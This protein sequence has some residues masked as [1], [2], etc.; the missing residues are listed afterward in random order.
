MEIMMLQ[1]DFPTTSVK[2]L[3][4]R[5]G[6]TERAIN[7]FA[8]K[9]GLKKVQYGLEWTPRMLSLLTKYFPTMFNR[10]LAQ[11]I[12]V[13]MR[14]VIRKARELGLE[15]VP[16]FHQRKKKEIALLLSAKQPKGDAPTRIKKGEHRCPEHEFKAGHRETEEQKAKRIA[17]YKA[18]MRRKKMLKAYG[19][20][21]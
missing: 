14:S 1:R 20:E 7:T 5:L 6:R 10:Q 13:S 2:I 21:G 12:G 11:L 16:D 15:K 8:S 17:A 4:K 19:L 9:L 3:S 18:T